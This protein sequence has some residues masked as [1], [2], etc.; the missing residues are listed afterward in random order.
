MKKALKIVNIL[1]AIDFIILASSGI[2]HNLVVP[3]GLYPPLHII[4]GFT[5]V[6]LVVIHLILNRKWIKATYFTKKKD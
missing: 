5:L 2:L 3:T 1:L 4:P 6:T